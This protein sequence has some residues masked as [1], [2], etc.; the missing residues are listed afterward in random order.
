MATLSLFME[1]LPKYSKEDWIIGLI[2]FTPFLLYFII[3]LIVWYFH[4]KNS[5]RR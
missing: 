2:L 5:V 4:E 1:Q 3:D